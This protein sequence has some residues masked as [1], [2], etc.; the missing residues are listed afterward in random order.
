MERA[1][2]NRLR[3][4]AVSRRRRPWRI[5]TA[6]DHYIKAV[7]PNGLTIVLRENHAAPVASLWIWYRVGSRNEHPG[8]TGAAHWVEHLLFKG[9][10]RYTESEMDRLIS[11][12]GGARNG[13]TWI[14]W[15]TYYET[16][17]A[18]KIDLA[19]DIEADRMVNALIEPADV[20]NE[21]AVIL[22]ERR[23]AENSPTFRLFE[24]VQ[25]AAF[26]VHPYGHEVIGYLCDLESMTRDELLSFYRTYYAP[27][28]AVLALAGDFEA[29]DMLARIARR[30]GR[31][32]PAMRIPR[33]SAVEPDQTGERRVIVKGE[34]ATNYVLLAFRSVPATH[35]DFFP[36]VALDSVLCGASGLSFTGAV[37][38]NRTSRLSQALV[39]TGLAADVAGGVSPTIDPYLYILFATLQPGSDIDALERALWAELDRVRRRPVSQDE[40]DKAIKQT[41]AQFVFG[42]ESV[43]NQAFWLGFSEMCADY[44]WFYTYLDR[45]S[46]VTL[47]DVQ[48]VANTYLSRDRAT[49]GYY[50]GQG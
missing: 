21:R 22:N 26:K 8:M 33:V 5:V 15:T 30:F 50:L 46:A 43:T 32:K 17:P 48:R 47:Q 13:M 38:T 7:L 49:V 25:A 41:K 39:D 28:N 14:D 19:L 9:T 16:L 1:P 20:R 35:P 40:L 3:S 12:E 23:G 4:K 18:D 27:N 31:L 36:L 44:G 37:A 11:R 34:G 10:P 29:E 42:A 6:F 45:L 24:E 2:V